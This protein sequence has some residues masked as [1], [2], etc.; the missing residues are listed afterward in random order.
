VAGVLEGVGRPYP[1][2]EVAEAL[3]GAIAVINAT[4]AGLSNGGRIEIPLQASPPDAVIMDM[5]YTPLETPFLKQARDLGRQTVDGLA[6]LIGQAAPSF[7]AFFGLPP[8]GE[9]DVRALALE[10]LGQA[11]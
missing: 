10:A 4:S 9:M 7:E 11:A 3:D 5:V 2:D 6:M 1:L 8:P